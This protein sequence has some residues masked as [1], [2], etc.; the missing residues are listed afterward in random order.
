[1]AAQRGKIEPEADGTWDV[2]A[3]V[4]S[5]R[6]STLSSL[7]RPS[8]TRLD[9]LDPSRDFDDDGLAALIVNTRTEGGE[10][11][12]AEDDW[13]PLPPPAAVMR[14]GTPLSTAALLELD[15]TVPGGSWWFGQVTTWAPTVAATL[16]ITDQ[17]AVVA[18]LRA[19][20]RES[21]AELATD[22]A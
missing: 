17:A 16:G 12:D 14:A 10:V 18:V 19:V 21:L 8:Q 9:V 15:A 2:I 13:R 4:E 6:C 1:M 5:W 11:L 3:C 22:L 7:Q 20:V